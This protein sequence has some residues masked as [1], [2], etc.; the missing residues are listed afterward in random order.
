[1]IKN[2]LLLASLTLLVGITSSP[3][4]AQAQSADCGKK[5][6]P[7]SNFDQAAAPDPAVAPEPFNPDLGYEKIVECLPVST[8]EG[9]TWESIVGTVLSTLNTIVAILA[10]FG[11][12]ISGI[13]YITAGG[14][15]EKA[16]KA[17]RNI[18]W[19]IAGILIYMF[20]LYFLPIIRAVMSQALGGS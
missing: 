13:M 7:N 15:T 19:V 10:I 3:T 4:I 17:K 9:L 1:M 20:A 18:G 14:D 12:I 11:L 5:D 6:N 16:E 8:L 2:L